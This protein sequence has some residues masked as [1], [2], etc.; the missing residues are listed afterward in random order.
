MKIRIL[1]H[2]KI[3]YRMLELELTEQGFEI[4][5]SELSEDETGYPVL[6]DL[7]CCELD[8]LKKISQS[9]EIFGW[10]RLDIQDN[11]SSQ[12]CSCVFERPFLMSELRAALG[13]FISGE[14]VAQRTKAPQKRVSEFGRRKNMLTCN[15]QK[16]EAVFG[17]HSIPLSPAEADV[18]KLLCDNRGEVVSREQ[19]NELF[20]GHDGN[21]SDVYICKLRNKI[22]N[23]LGIKF[24]YT[25]KGVGYMLK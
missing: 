24:I 9:C 16:R 22:D 5:D 20:S 1:T 18:L 2:D 6:C 11:P 7:D 25:V 19:L 13:K 23:K 21:I 4:I 17:A 8:K 10:T 14:K 3:F 12:L 15:H